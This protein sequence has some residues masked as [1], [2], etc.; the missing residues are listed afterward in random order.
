MPTRS[1]KTSI[2]VGKFD[3]V[4][5]IE[6]RERKS[7]QRY[8]ITP[9]L[10]ARY[11]TGTAL[12]LKVRSKFGPDD[13]LVHRRAPSPTARSR[14]SSSTSTTRS[15]PTSARRSAAASRCTR[16]S[17]STW[18]S[19]SRAP[20]AR[21]TARRTTAGH[22]VVLRASTISCTLRRADLK[23]QWLKGAAPGDPANDVYGLELHGGGYVEV[24][25]FLTAALRRP[26]ARRVPRR[27]RL[28]GRSQRAGRRQPRL[29]HAIV[30]RHGRRAR[31]RSP[32]GSCS[33]PSTCTTAST[34]GFP[35]IKNDVFTTSLV[36]ID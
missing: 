14:R 21:R 6:Y 5:G 20:T 2:F 7:D 26:R 25:G 17:R 18:S 31:R 4:L 12:G 35:Q 10:I 3:S 19:A 1:Q 28:A 22:D 24:D 13:L 16:R 29:P 11:T 33:R 30:A 27:L 36:L 23:A 9:S 8:G 34:A 15:T 32:I